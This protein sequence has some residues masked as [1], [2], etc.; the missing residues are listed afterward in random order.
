MVFQLEMTVRGHLINVRIVWLGNGEAQGAYSS[1][2]RHPGEG[3]EPDLGADG[4]ARFRSLSIPGWWFISEY[5]QK[6]PGQLQYGVGHNT[7]NC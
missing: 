6:M 1:L 5:G 3:M 4:Q 7:I 2:T